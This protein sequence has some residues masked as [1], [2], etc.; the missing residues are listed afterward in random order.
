MQMITPWTAADAG[1][2]HDLRVPKPTHSTEPRRVHVTLFFGKKKSAS[3]AILPKKPRS[4]SLTS[5]LDEGSLYWEN[6]KTGK[7]VML[8]SSHESVHTEI[9]TTVVAAYYTSKYSD[10]QSLS[11]SGEN[12]L[13]MRVIQ[14]LKPHFFFTNYTTTPLIRTL[15]MRTA[16]YPERFGPLSKFMENSTKLSYLE[17]NCYRIKYN[18]VLWLP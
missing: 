11:P 3:N 4:F 1:T 6:T 8:L 7:Q 10:L 12:V 5:V 13:T 14:W 9:L 15:V 16:N 18:T 2:P 17:I